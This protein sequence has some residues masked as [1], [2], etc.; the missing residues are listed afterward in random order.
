MERLALAGSSRHLRRVSERGTR[1]WVA[2]PAAALLA[3]A[4]AAC[5]S[6]SKS[7]TSAK[8]DSSA[9]APAQITGGE[10]ALVSSVRPVIDSLVTA[11]QGTDVAKARIAY[12]DY[13]SGWNGIEVYVNVR[14]KALYTKLEEDLQDPIGE[15][16]EAPSPNLAVLVPRAQD[17]GKAFDQAIANSRNGPKLSPLFDDVTALRIVRRDL[18]RTTALLQDGDFAGAKTRFTSFQAHYPQVQARVKQRS[19]TADAPITAAI[20]AAAKQVIVGQFWTDSALQQAL[21][22]LPGA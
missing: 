9:V 20:D 19:D 12:A 6:S 2:G 8:T 3:V 13:D 11:L 16:L 15:A 18:R 17:L 1:R 10:V 4:V 5:G 21:A 14:D 22:K 7:T